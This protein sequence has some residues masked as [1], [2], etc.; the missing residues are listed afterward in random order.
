MVAINEE[1]DIVLVS[2][3]SGVDAVCLFLAVALFFS[4]FID[5]VFSSGLVIGIVVVKQGIGDDDGNG[6]DVNFFVF[7][8]SV[9]LSWLFFNHSFW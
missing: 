4:K 8:L 6:L 5:K 1:L 2:S 3:M 7:S 9:K